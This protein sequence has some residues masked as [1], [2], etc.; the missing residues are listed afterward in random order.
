VYPS[1]DIA[2]GDKYPQSQQPIFLQEPELLLP[3]PDFITNLQLSVGK[4]FSWLKPGN[5]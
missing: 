5:V 2:L 4:L 3:T 1:F